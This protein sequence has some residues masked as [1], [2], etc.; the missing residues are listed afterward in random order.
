[1]YEVKRK[2][3][4]DFQLI[5]LIFIC[6]V[7]LSNKDEESMFQE[8]RNKKGGAVLPCPFSIIGGGFP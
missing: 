8:E 2:I 5:L 6:N 3:S 4:R 7:V 1:M